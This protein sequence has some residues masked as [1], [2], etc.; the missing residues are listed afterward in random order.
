MSTRSDTF[1]RPMLAKEVREPFSDEH[2]IYE[3]KWDGYRAIAELHGLQVRL[4]SRSGA[5]FAPLFPN[6]VTA[7]AQLNLDTVLDGEIIA[8]DAD[9][10]SCIEYLEQYPHRP[11]LALRYQVFD[12]LYKDGHRLEDQPLLWRKQLLRDVILKASELIRFSEHVRGDGVGFFR[13]AVAGGLEGVMG[14]RLDSAYAEGHRS[15]DWLKIKTRQEDEA[16]IVGYTPSGLVLGR[17]LE[18][19]LRFAGFVAVTPP[20]E[21]VALPVAEASFS[22]EDIPA[23]VRWVSPTLVC[24]IRYTELDSFGRFL[25]ARFAGLR[26]DKEPHEVRGHD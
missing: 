3:V 9:G 6:L 2:W 17:Y 18:L 1:I 24:G 7:L 23:D 15:P 10:R 16:I 19:R 22:L 8:V 14:K 13:E 4:Y 12:L 5:D 26:R 11:G 20:D 21:V 25:G